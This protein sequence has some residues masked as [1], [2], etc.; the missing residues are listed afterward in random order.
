MDKIKGIFL[1]LGGTLIKPISNDWYL[2]R[3]MLEYTSSET[4][5]SLPAI[6]IEAASSKAFQYMSEHHLLKTTVEE[7]EQF[8][9]YYKIIAAELPELGLNDKQAGEIAEAKV[10]NISDYELIGDVK[11]TLLKLK[12]KYKLGIISDTWPAID[13][14]LKSAEIY[15]LFDSRTYSCHLGIMK[16]DKKMYQHALGQLDLPPEQT[17]FVD[18]SAANLEGAAKC[19]IK[20]IL[21]NTGY[22][23]Q[24]FGQ[25][26][27]NNAGNEE[28]YPT[29]RIINELP[30]LLKDAAKL[31]TRS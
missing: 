7:V 31:F 19:G 11:D 6:R 21:I 30:G 4:I 18:D 13:L 14:I 3:K 2:N 12:P 10:L 26:H 9:E 22:D 16:P 20:P 24:F 29:I 28:K 17:V 25:G 1:D 23:I 15:D 8:T 27:V 5:C